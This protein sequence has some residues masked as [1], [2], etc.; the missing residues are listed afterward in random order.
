MFQHG[1]DEGPV[2]ELVLHVF[3]HGWDQERSAMEE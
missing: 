1:L 3:G 2:M